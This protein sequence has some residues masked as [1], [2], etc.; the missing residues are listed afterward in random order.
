M[1]CALDVKLEKVAGEVGAAGAMGAYGQEDGENS[2]GL[3]ID[4]VCK[5]AWVGY[6]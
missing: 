5:L 3:V 4:G 2:V 1:F 6:E